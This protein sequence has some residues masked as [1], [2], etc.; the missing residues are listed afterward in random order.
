ML[1]LGPGKSRYTASSDFSTV[2][3]PISSPSGVRR[4]KVIGYAL[5]LRRILRDG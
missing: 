5:V 3:E 4:W 1:V 2:Y